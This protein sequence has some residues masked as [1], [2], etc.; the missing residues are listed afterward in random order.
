MA[1]TLTLEISDAAIKRHAGDPS[2]RELN[3]SRYAYR[4]R[5]NKSREGG[6]WHVVRSVK[7]KKIWR[8]AGSFPALTTK[9]LKAELPNILARMAADPAAVA[10]VGVM[11]TVGDVLA[12]YQRRM[13]LDRNV[14]QKRKDAIRS[15]IKV[16][17]RKVAG[18]QLVEVTKRNLDDLLLWPMQAVYSLAYTRSVFAVLKAAC[19]TARRL[20]VI[21]LD[22]VAGLLFSDSIPH[23][24]GVKAMQLQ[25][26]GIE[27]L[28]A[29]WAELFD[30]WPERVT[31]AVLQLCFG[32]R[33]GESR[34]ASW[35]EVT[36][37]RWRIPA[38]HTK[39]RTELS[40]PMPAQVWTFLERY[41]ANQVAGGYSGNLL[42]PGSRSG[43]PVGE[44]QAAE[45]YTQLGG[46]DWTS[47]D[48]RK[49]ARTTWFDLGV[50]TLT[51]E[52]L[53]NHKI[54]GVK[55]HYIHTHAESQKR[56]ALDLWLGWLE[57]R[58]FG[59]LLG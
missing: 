35:S 56:Q 5:Y 33:I 48:L 38:A 22:P 50:D 21:T 31:L 13:M 12:W 4:F 36:A 23:K 3:D 25:T 2:V 55:A 58:G 47:H 24:I 59:A 41:R 26:E 40:L 44:R 9:A 52:L 46:G 1:H 34:R 15:A 37:N 28:L 32:T 10:T 17:L 30:R 14:T 49:L 42:F 16:H 18:L 29:G 19:K 20:E 7:G 57:R 8:K 45:W 39:T 6:S 43:Q 53:L 51:G 54:D 11:D 27:A